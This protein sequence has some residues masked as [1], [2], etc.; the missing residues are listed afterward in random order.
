MVSLHSP[1]PD[2]VVRFE[3]CT[4]FLAAATVACGSS[5]RSATPV[6]TR[7]AAPAAAPAAIE[8]A[9][10]AP[11]LNIDLNAMTKTPSGLYYRDVV[12]GTGATAEV[13]KRVGVRYIGQL[14]DGNQ[15]DASRSGDPPLVFTPGSRQV[16]PG[17]EEG[18]P[19]AKIGGKRQ[20]V[21][22]PALAYGPEGSGPI[23][24]N[25]ILVFTVEIVSVE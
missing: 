22:P 18:I 7:S 25:A 13:G 8:T 9:T 11:S 19:G 16:I 5:D 21:I 6:A 2:V 23:P 4:A 14:V 1:F 15:F 10:F 24:P 3:H 12:V 17:W 20:L